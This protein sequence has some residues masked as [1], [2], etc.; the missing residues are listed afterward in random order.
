MPRLKIAYLC[1]IH[2]EHVN[3]Y[4]GGNHRIH[5][6][7]SQ[8]ADVTTLPQDWGTLEPVR[9]AINALSDAAQLRLRWRTHLALARRIAARNNRLLRSGGFDVIFGAYSFQSMSRI[10]PPPG[11]LSVFTS[12]A[13]PTV[14]K[15]SEIGQAFGSSWVS[16]HLLDPLTLRAERRIF[17]DIDLLLWPSEWIEREARALYDLPP[18]KAHVLP[19]GANVPDPGKAPAP[20]APGPGTPLELLIIGRDWFAKGGPMAFD[21]MKALRARGHDARLTV[22][23]CT[24]P[25]FHMSEQ[26]T[27][28]G[29][30]D[31]GKPADAARFDAALRGAHL[32]IQPSVESFGFAFCEAAA[33]GLPA[34]AYDIGGVPVRDGISGQRLA[35]AA[36]PED[37]ADVVEKLVAVPARYAALRESARS[38]YE[39]RL[40]WDAW[41]DAALALIEERLSGKR[42]KPGG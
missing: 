25:E 2:P 42:A 5:A 38:E 23:G 22:I 8:R 35:R 26:V 3:P 33:Y 17:S 9:R 19:W 28:T 30:L 20:A 39:T 6:A 36:S 27:L 21:T 4:S 14:Y 31:K 1:D 32:L 13:T 11:A 15:R 12:D 29:P 34:L 40:N 18:A 10:K 37:F 7:L 16:R 24:P 41:A